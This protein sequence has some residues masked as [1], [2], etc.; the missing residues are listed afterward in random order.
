M[1]LAWVGVQ[2]IDLDAE[3]DYPFEKPLFCAPVAGGLHLEACQVRYNAWKL[4]GNIA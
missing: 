2:Q 1:G 4:T 3:Q